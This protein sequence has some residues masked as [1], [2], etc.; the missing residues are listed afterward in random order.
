MITK[1]LLPLGVHFTDLIQSISVGAAAPGRISHDTHTWVY[2]TSKYTRI[3]A[4]ETGEVHKSA[5]RKS[6]KIK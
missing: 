5:P 4:R 3:L 6:K 2:K 1:L